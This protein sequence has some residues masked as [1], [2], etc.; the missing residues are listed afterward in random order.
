MAWSGLVWF[1][2]VWFGLVWLV[3][4]V[5]LLFRSVSGMSVFGILVCRSVSVSFCVW[6]VSMCW[7]WLCR[8]ACLCRQVS[9]DLCRLAC[10]SVSVGL[11]RSLSVSLSVF[12]VCVLLWVYSGGGGFIGDT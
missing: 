1:G 12:G 2:L 10:L 4:P 9:V 7:V 5:I 11:C 8:S 3:G 6:Y